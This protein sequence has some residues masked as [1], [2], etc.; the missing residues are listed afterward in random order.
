[1]NSHQIN[2]NDISKL[3]FSAIKGSLV[4]EEGWTIERADAVEFE[5]R[6]FLI[7]AKMFPNERLTPSVDVDAFWHY[8]ILDTR[9]YA[10]DCE[11]ALGHF[12]HHSPSMKDAEHDQAAV[13]DRM[14][15][16]Y[17]S[18]FGA[19]EVD[20]KMAFC[21]VL[22]VEVTEMA[23]CDVPPVESTKMA[24]CA[25][26]PPELTKMGFRTALEPALTTGA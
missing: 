14:K 13:M 12:L 9:K 21:A 6:R 18:V 23:F 19:G 10:T 17:L 4:R 22:P 15:S 3:D 2:L 25:V 5:Y 11:H 26:L 1:M 16:L 7:L 24:F 8:H 20:C